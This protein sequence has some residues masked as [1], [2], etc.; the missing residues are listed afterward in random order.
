[1]K[2]KEL[3]K[4]LGIAV[5][6]NEMRDMCEKGFAPK[7]FNDNNCGMKYMVIPVERNG[8]VEKHEYVCFPFQHDNKKALYVH[9]NEAS[10]RNLI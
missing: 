7:V 8:K 1:M 2:R 9:I 4:L 5:D 6:K 10:K 3:K